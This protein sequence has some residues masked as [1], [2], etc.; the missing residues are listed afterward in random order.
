[1]NLL[2]GLN[3]KQHEAVINTEGPNLIIA[4]AGSRE[5]KSINTQNSILNRRK[6]CKTMANTCNYIYK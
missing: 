6:K 3:D 1:M 4:G 2:E 5:N